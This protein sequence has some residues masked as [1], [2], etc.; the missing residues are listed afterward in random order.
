LLPDL[1]DLY[2]RL[3]LEM[4]GEDELVD[5]VDEGFDAGVRVGNLPRTYSLLS[6]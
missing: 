6:E 3:M 5:I 2:P 4:V 1:L